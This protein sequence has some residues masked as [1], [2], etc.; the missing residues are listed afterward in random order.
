MIDTLRPEPYLGGDIEWNVGTGEP[1]ILGLSDGKTTVSVP[2]AEGEPYLRR[3]LDRFPE[4]QFVG[5]NIMSAD[6]PVLAAKGIRVKQENCLDSIL[7]HWLTNSSLCKASGKVSDEEGEKRGRGYMNLFAFVAL[8]TDL[9]N[10]KQC[11]GESC[12]ELGNPCPEHDEQFYCGVDT[13]SVVMAMPHVLRRA[14]LM[15]VDKLYP[16]HR[17][18]STVLYGMR[19]R[20]LL[21]DT[22]Y[23]EQLDGQLR[24]EGE[25]LRLRMPFNPNSPKQV[26]AHFKQKGIAL[27]NAQQSTIDVAC[28]EYEDEELA[29]LQMYGQLGNGV[30]RWFKPQRYDADTGERD[31]YVDENG[32]IHANLSFFTS[33][34]RLACGSP[35]LQNIAHRP[36]KWEKGLPAQ[37]TLAGRIRRAVVAPEGYHLYEA[38]FSNAE[39]RVMLHLAGHTAPEGVDL[40]EWVAQIA[41]IQPDDPFALKEGGPRAA[42]KTV[43]HGNFYLEGLSLVTRSELRSGRIQ[44]EIAKG[45]RLAYPDWTFNGDVVTFTGSNFA[46]RAF[47]SASYENRVKANTI[48]GRL[49]SRFP[50][51]RDL[52]RRKSKEIE[53]D[54]CIRNEFGYCL[55]LYGRDMEKMKSGLAFTGS[56]PIAHLTKLAML[57]A[58]QHPQLDCRLQ[59][60]DSLLFYADRRHE[61]KQVAAWIKECMEIPLPEMGGLC[62]PVE[63]KYGMD[64]CNLSKLKS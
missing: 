20:G 45:V 35:N 32:L 31:G 42:A 3:L 21:V 19:E 46:K 38:D 2:F 43:Q 13:V 1:T 27:A 18:L 39:N 61:P 64:W 23:V 25:R 26:L 11:W 36:K 59:V 8:Y 24:Q 62:V 33:T 30:D 16:L 34:G 15:G 9:P 53:R 52:Q 10:W 54:R 55:A 12:R 22:K 57:R 28:E 48:I 50:G 47:G 29:V 44:N 41:E 51:V 5:H 56:N 60:H 17:D 4:A 40:H 49:F 14:K 63:V 37:D 7:L 58:D 6:V